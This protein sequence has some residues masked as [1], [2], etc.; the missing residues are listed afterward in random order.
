M[1]SGQFGVPPAGAPGMGR[2]YAG[3]GAM[4][5]A[6]GGAAPMVGTAYGYGEAKLLHISQ[7]QYKW[8]SL[9]TESSVQQHWLQTY[10]TVKQR[11][12]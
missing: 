9:M 6:Y 1:L 3:Y 10:C 2:G 5:P 7:H 11:C 12:S 8:V 4:T